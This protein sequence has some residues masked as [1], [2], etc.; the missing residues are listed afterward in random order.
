MVATAPSYSLGFASALRFGIGGWSK[1]KDC[2]E[3]TIVTCIFSLA[4]LIS[5]FQYLKDVEVVAVLLHFGS[6][7]LTT[8]KRLKNIDI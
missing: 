6:Q 2:R 4:W 3:C 8:P 7:N 5:R 1:V